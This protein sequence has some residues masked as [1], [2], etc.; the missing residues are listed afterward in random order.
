MGRPLWNR[1]K[2]IIIYF[3]RR[4]PKMEHDRR[5]QRVKLVKSEASTEHAD[6]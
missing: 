1:E 6:Y 2:E 3:Q 4:L 5:R